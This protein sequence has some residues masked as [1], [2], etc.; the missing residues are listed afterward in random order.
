[1]S[2]GHNLRMN[3]GYSFKF[4]RQAIITLHVKKRHR[5]QYLLYEKVKINFSVSTCHRFILCT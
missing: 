5:F 2:V 4:L 3:K 1:L